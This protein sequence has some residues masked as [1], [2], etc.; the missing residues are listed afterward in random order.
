MYGGIGWMEQEVGNDMARS[1]C[2]IALASVCA[3]KEEAR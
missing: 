1:V 2:M 3:S